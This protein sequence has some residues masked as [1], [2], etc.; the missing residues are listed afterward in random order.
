MEGAG[1]LNESL[2]QSHS[3]IGKT[4]FGYK[5][6]HFCE[7]RKPLDA[8]VCCS[9]V[10]YPCRVALLNFLLWNPRKDLGT[11]DI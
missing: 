8:G 11:L 10:R 9:G 4:H 3:S 7:C 2:E 5:R 6:S 1:P